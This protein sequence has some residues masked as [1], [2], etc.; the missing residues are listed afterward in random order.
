MQDGANDSP[1]VPARAETGS[2][3]GRGASALLGIGMIVGLTL[4]IGLM[5]GVS[6]TS[7]FL[8]PTLPLPTTRDSVE[9]LNELND[10]RLQVN[11]LNE[12]KKGKQRESDEAMRRALSAVASAVRAR[13]SGATGSP[14]PA[15]KPGMSAAAPA[16]RRSSD[17]FVE[18]DDEIKSLE[19][20]QKVLNTIL[21]LFLPSGKEPAKDRKDVPAPPE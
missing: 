8:S 20:T 14:P 1:A 15:E 16:V 4:G 19:D 17:P 2:A 18:L 5:A 12:E 3:A 13:A 21:D 6:A 11:Q 9:I 10:L 7:K